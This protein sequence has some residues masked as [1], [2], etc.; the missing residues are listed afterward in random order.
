MG[1][2]TEKLVKICTDKFMLHPHCTEVS[3]VEASIT[4]TSVSTVWGSKEENADASVGLVGLASAISNL[5]LISHVFHV[6][7]LPSMKPAFQVLKSCKM[8][9]QVGEWCT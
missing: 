8:A 4:F 3:K 9:H 5:S 1:K 2:T 7:E 6:G